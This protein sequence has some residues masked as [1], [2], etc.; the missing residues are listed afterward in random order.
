MIYRA[1]ANKKE[2]SSFNLGGKEVSQIC[3]GNTLLWKKGKDKELFSIDLSYGIVPGGSDGEISECKEHISFRNVT[4]VGKKQYITDFTKAGIVFK[5]SRSGSYGLE[6]YLLYKGKVTGAKQ[7]DILINAV[8]T[9]KYGDTQSE[10][11]L[12]SIIGSKGILSPAFDSTYSYP[13]SYFL[14]ASPISITYSASENC[15]IFTDVD[16]MVS[17]VLAE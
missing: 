16:K 17:W 5:Q 2:I 9:R 8:R 10:R 7:G 1:Y 12:T 14:V 15:K 6:I 11:T 13:Q 3:G 4:Q